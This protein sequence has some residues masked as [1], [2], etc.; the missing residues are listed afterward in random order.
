M[1]DR[2]TPGVRPRHAVTFCLRWYPAAAPMASWLPDGAVRF[3][4]CPNHPCG[5]VVEDCRLALFEWFVAPLSVYAVWQVSYV[6]KTEYV[7]RAKLLADSQLMTSFRWLSNSPG[8]LARRMMERFPRRYWILVFIAQQLL[9]T[10]LT[11][12]LVPL[13]FASQAW[14]LGVLAGALFATLL[15]CV[16]PL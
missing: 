10:V 2:P 6:V 11:L 12:Q 16:V 9:Y 7:D 1:H 3:A 13:M 5:A 15:R 8:H 4:T 14:H